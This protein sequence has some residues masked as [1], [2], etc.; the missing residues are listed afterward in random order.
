MA[1]R[2]YRL[3]KRQ[4]VVE[5]TRAEI[6]AVARELISSSG[7]HR[8]S[9]DQV[10]ERAAVTRATVYYQFGSKLGLFEAV[11]AD[12]EHRAGIERLATLAR[13]APADVLPRFFREHVR[14]WAADPVLV[15]HIMGLAAIDED[16]RRVV[17][18]RD[19]GR[20]ADLRRMVAR[21]AGEGLLRNGISV[22]Q[23]TDVLWLLSSFQTFDQLHRRSGLSVRATSRTLT[24]L[25]QAILQ[26]TD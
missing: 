24:E 2:P 19:A 17:E 13:V 3:G 9:V 1:P 16:A 11:A 26:P 5:R 15:R 7:Y 22:D 21:V 6:I 20:R 12:F 4:A 10:A 8:M 18:T 25:G 23:A 14:L